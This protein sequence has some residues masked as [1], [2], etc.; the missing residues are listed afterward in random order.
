MGQIQLK[1]STDKLLTSATGETQILVLCREHTAACT[2][3]SFNSRG[4]MAP[5]RIQKVHPGKRWG[6]GWGGVRDTGF[7]RPTD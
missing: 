7:A 6:L 5:W 3:I 2:G 1:I 4:Q